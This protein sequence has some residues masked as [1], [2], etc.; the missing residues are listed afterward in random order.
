LPR[1]QADPEQ[2]RQLLQNLI[3]NALKFRRPE[4]P[5]AVRVHGEVLPPAAPAEVS[6][7]RVVVDDN[8]LGFEQQYAGR[9]FE[10][11]QR[12]HGRSHSE[13]VGLGL[14]ICRRIVER[15][16]GTIAAEG[17]PREGARFVVTLPSVQH[18]EEQS[19]AQ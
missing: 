2:M 11:F 18:V 1:L 16:G 7:V 12:L 14:A 15:H 10:L 4:V 6:R 19:S 9:I 17:V 3:G 8:G 5:L 13:G